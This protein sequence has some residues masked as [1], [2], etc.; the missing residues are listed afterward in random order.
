MVWAAIGWDWKSDLIFLEREPGKKGICSTVYTNQVLEAVIGPCYALLSPGQ[1]EKFIFIEDGAKVHMGAVRV[2]RL[3]HGVRGFDCPPL[4]PDLNPIEKVWRWMKH[5]ITK[6]ESAPMLKEDMKEVL[7]ELWSEVKPED[8]RYLT[9][10]L[11]CK[12]EDVIGNKG[13]ATVH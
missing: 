11:T 4:S 9:Y 13:M 2:W 3:N 5:E 12:L 1:Q 6:L 8:W 10:R 7:R